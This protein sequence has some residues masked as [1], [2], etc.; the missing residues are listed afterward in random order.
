[1]TYGKRA[2][3]LVFALNFFSSP[4]T[5]M[6]TMKNSP[7]LSRSLTATTCSIS[8]SAYLL[9]RGMKTLALR[10]ERHNETGLRV[11]RWLEG[12]PRVR[13]VWY[14]GLESHPDYA[15]ATRLMQGFGGVV[16]FELETDFEGAVRFTDACEMPYIAP[17]LGGVDSLIE[18]P[19]LMSY[20]DYPPAE[21][22]S[23]GITDS[24]IRYSCGIE[25]ADDLIADLEQ[26][27]T[28]I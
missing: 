21:R 27:L 24:L 15:V 2:K 18:M 8:N 20:W 9:L 14:P 10:M 25:D 5:P 26:A 23:Y 11:A 19:V 17:S 22:Q 1:M 6:S 3:C 13:R 4:L 16:T 7:L 28:R 12:Q